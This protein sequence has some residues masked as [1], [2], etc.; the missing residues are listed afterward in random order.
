[1]ANSYLTLD[2][3]DSNEFIDADGKNWF[4]LISPELL[5]KLDILRGFRTAPIHISKASGAIGRFL[6]ENATSK[7]N[8]D[9][10][11]LVLAIDVFPSYE[12][13]LNPKDFLN[14]AEEVGFRGVGFYPEWE[15]H[16]GSKLLKGGFHLDVRPNEVMGDP[17][18]WGFIGE[19]FVDIYT[20]IEYYRVAI[21]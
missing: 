5:V 4:N 7:H 16:T 9:K 13:H 18:T 10:W 14:L 19:D 8:I 1:M 6:G 15:M 21:L 20:A 17:A 3:F 12:P 11:G 2:H